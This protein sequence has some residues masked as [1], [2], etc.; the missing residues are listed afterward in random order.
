VSTGGDETRFLPT[1]AAH[2]ATENRLLLDLIAD[3]LMAQGVWPEVRMLTRRLAQDGR[4]IPLADLLWKMPRSLG[5]I[6]TQNDRI[7][8]LLFAL[9]LT[10]AG[11]ALLT[12]FTAIL[13]LA[14]D[15][16]RDADPQ[17]MIRRGDVVEL[18]QSEPYSRALGEILLREAPFLGGGE[19][20]LDDDWYRHVTEAVVRYWHVQSPDDYLS[21]RASELQGNPQL[22]WSGVPDAAVSASSD[23]SGSSAAQ[24][25]IAAADLNA[26]IRDGK[27]VAEGE[28]LIGEPIGRGGFGQVYAARCD[29]LDAAVKFVEKA[30]GA[31]RELLFADLADAINVVPVIDNGEY[32]GFWFLVMPRAEISLRGWLDRG[33]TP[34]LV[35]ILN[36]GRDVADA[37]VS[38][39]GR[40]VHRDLKPENILLLGGRWCLAD[41]GISRYAEATTAQDTKKLALTAAYAAP[42]RW[43]QE[44]ATSAA[45][46]YALGAVMFEMA[47]G[48]RPFVC[49]SLEE[50]R[51]AHLHA[52]PPELDQVPAALAALVA[53]CLYKA[54]QA[55]PTP[56][57]LRARLERAAESAQSPG[58][59]RLQEANRGAVARLSEAARQESA[60]RTEQ[61]RRAALVAAAKQGYAAISRELLSTICG[62]APAAAVTESQDDGWTLRLNTATLALSAIHLAPPWDLAIDVI[63]AGR[64]DLSVPPN[65]Y[66]YD[67]RG[68]SLWFGDIQT[69]GTI[70]W[71][72]TAFTL[73]AFS[74]QIA[75]KDPFALDPGPHA[76]EALGTGATL[77]QVAWPFTPLEVGSLD[78]F[79]DRWAGWFAGAASGHLQRM[80]QPERQPQG[81]WRNS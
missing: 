22:G 19:G 4:P 2:W 65:A 10:S 6:D 50:C 63:C 76:H 41:F 13:R 64:L 1:D 51:D 79:L 7:I 33:E 32:D 53:E 49:A 36:V 72:E 54:P 25:E 27:V 52:K 44:R 60:A 73:S 68:H 5:F 9:D 80:S 70:Q 40:V 20:G 28:W 43:R 48:S 56:A 55:R 61:E 59:A 8:L 81:S 47:A 58:L 12:G 75:Q 67:G 69:A 31:A 21:V 16:Y 23:E 29:E 71:Y 39:D 74:G 38:L 17:P 57:N 42:E 46:V 35:E 14:V 30:P 45:D 34:S 77:R 62:A 11:G 78:D 66:G 24:P 3:E 15:R 26:L 18:G 37:L